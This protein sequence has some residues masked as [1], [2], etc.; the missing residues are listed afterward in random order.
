APP[1]SRAATSVPLTVK[2]W[3]L[4]SPF[5]TEMVDPEVTEKQF[6]LNA[7]FLIVSVPVSLVAFSDVQSLPPP[8][9]LPPQAA[10]VSASTTAVASKAFVMWLPPRLFGNPSG[11]LASKRG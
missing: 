7:K 6:G 11:L 9:P 1:G 10:P 5:A 4:A 2:L 3:A 8:P